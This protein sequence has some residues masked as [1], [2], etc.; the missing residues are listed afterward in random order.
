MI[1]T[2]KNTSFH[3]IP[4]LGGVNLFLSGDDS[5]VVRYLATLSDG[6]SGRISRVSLA[7]TGD[8]G[9][10]LVTAGQE[11]KLWRARSQTGSK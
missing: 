6:D 4:R 9:M 5:E 3:P 10:T 8:D 7:R 11:R 2:R 1:K